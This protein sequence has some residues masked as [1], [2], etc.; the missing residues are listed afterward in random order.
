MHRRGFTLIE[1]LV[2]IAIIAI[3]AAIL[4]PALARA[5]EAA[6]RASCASNLKQFGIIFKM[7]SNENKSKFPPMATKSRLDVNSG[8]FGYMLGFDGAELY[9]DYWNDPS[10]V[11][12]PSDASGDYV[13]K[14]VFKMESDYN[15]MID[16]VAKST[17]GTADAKKLCLESLLSVP[18]SYC[19]SGF[20]AMTESQI[21][22]Y[23]WSKANFWYPPYTKNIMGTT[24]CVFSNVD[25]SAVD[26]SACGLKV[27]TCSCTLPDTLKSLY[28]PLG[29]KDND[30]VTNLPD[31]YYALKEGVERF[32]ITDINNPAAGSNGQSTM[33]VMWDA[34]V[35]N[36][37]LAGASDAGVARFN[38]VPSGSNVLY[39]DGHVSF[40]RL[41]AAS[42]IGS[43]FSN[44]SIAGS[45]SGTGQIGNQSY[46]QWTLSY[47][48]GMG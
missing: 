48:G 30:G 26:S 34:Y 25:V 15:A 45:T 11:R 5:R 7:Y 22:D 36:A 4:L 46:W 3:L 35:N 31:S 47:M 32:M 43:E 42:P 19:Y 17:T 38:H 40:V 44:K 1:L 8:I 21:A 28:K 16:R 41:N 10:I 23:A 29:F 37:T 24:S 18:I 14:D 9:P 2:V 12:C 27:Y 13:G 33:P 20:L 6:R 39:M